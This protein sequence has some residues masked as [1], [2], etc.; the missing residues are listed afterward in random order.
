MHSLQILILS[1][2]ISNTVGSPCI[3]SVG[4]TALVIGQD[5]DSIN[6]YSI[7]LGHEPFGVMSYT[8]LNSS[9][10][11]VQ[12]LDL[13][14]DYGSG[15]EWAAGSLRAHPGSSLQLGL[16]LVDSC[17]S[18][19]TG[20]LD[21]EIFNLGKFILNVRVPVYLR[22]GY[23]FDLQGNRYTPEQYVMAFHYIV[24]TFRAREIKNVAFVWHSWGGLPR[25]NI[26]FQLWFPG[27]TYVD[28]CGISLFEQPYECDPFEPDCT[29][30]HIDA[31]A[32]FCRDLNIP[33]MIA[34]ST[35]F[36]GIVNG[37]GGAGGNEA[38]YR[39]DSWTRW[40]IPVLGI[41]EK[42][43]IRMWSY[44][45]CDWDALPMWAVNHA[46]GVHW[47]DSRIEGR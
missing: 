31:M 46:P 34:E 33:M 21:R 7:T 9:T 19:V 27:K 3:P 40:F 26:P 45:N 5:Y 14:I 20:E 1:I 8:A 38:G 12:G 18:I 6:S 17:E 37:S 2:A 36:G 30:P 13:A 15:T 25:D 43:D 16:W 32:N 29:L 47:G 23:E 35:P 39:G 4:K 41:I 22:I 11:K 10:G 24:D 44:I 28:W 42:Y